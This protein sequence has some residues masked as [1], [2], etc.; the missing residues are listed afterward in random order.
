MALTPTDGEFIDLNDAK[1]YTKSFRET[2]SS[3]SKAQFFGTANL[4]DITDQ[5]DCVGIRIYNAIVNGQTCYVLVGATASGD[6]LTNGLLLA[7]GPVCPSI[8]DTSSPLYS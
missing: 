5:E 2:Y 7:C 1:S 3:Q 4:K 6:D 8:C